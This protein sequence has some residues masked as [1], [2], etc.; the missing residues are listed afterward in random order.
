MAKR[1]KSNSG[2]PSEDKHERFKRVVTPRV[3]KAIKAIG[4]I[5]NQAGSAYEYTEQDIAYIM[6]SLRGACDAV[7]KRYTSSGKQEVDFTLD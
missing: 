5:G 4:L 1:K 3:K 7:E 6:G 2:K